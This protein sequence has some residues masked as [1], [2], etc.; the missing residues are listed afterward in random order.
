MIKMTLRFQIF[1][2]D[3]TNVF[4]REKILSKTDNEDIEFK[5]R[6]AN[7]FFFRFHSCCDSFA[8]DMR[9]DLF[10]LHCL[11]IFNDK[12]KNVSLSLMNTKLIERHNKNQTLICI[13]QNVVNF[14][15]KIVIFITKAFE[16]K[17]CLLLLLESFKNRVVWIRSK[18]FKKSN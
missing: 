1:S 7:V 5:N 3:C 15:Q 18:H 10:F 2:F 16:I 12:D 6:E 8:I 17:K 13:K 11:H 14:F 9:I 4:F